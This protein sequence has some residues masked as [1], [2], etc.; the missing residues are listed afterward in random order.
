MRGAA[1][2][3]YA[4]RAALHMQHV[5]YKTQETTPAAT[6]QDVEK[7]GPGVPEIGLARPPPIGEFKHEALRDEKRIN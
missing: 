3:E 2:C 7:K 5:K 1:G 4:G 6:R